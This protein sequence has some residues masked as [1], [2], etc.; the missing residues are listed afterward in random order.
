MVPSRIIWVF[1][2]LHTTWERIT[3]LRNKCI[4]YFVENLIVENCMLFLLL[5]DK[6]SF[7]H[8]R[9]KKIGLSLIHAHFE[10]LIA[11]TGIFS[12]R[13]FEIGIFEP[14]SRRTSLSVSA[15]K[16]N[17]GRGI[18][19]MWF[20]FHLIGSSIN[21]WAAIQP[22]RFGKHILTH[23]CIESVDENGYEI[24]WNKNADAMIWKNGRKFSL[25]ITLAK[26]QSKSI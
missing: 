19:R 12:H 25:E 4:E 26:R 17:I 16:K 8:N 1:C 2:A 15:E 5:M 20:L 23:L 9:L 7:R 10:N 6:W 22:I 18:E 13:N 21:R 3:A 24:H 14:Y 11:T